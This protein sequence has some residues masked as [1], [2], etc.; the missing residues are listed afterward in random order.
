MDALGHRDHAAAEALVGGLHIGEERLEHEDA[1]RKVDQVRSV[2]MELSRHRRGRG[3]E[4]GVPAHDNYEVDTGQRC[5]IEVGTDERLGYKACRRWKSWR[6]I[7]AHQV[8]VDGFRNMDTAQR[9]AALACLLAEDAQGFGG[10]IAADIEEV[11]DSV[12]PQDLKDLLAVLGVGLVT[13]RTECWPRRGRDQL[14]LLRAFL[15][16]VDEVFGEDAGNAVTGAIDIFDFAEVTCCEH[17]AYQRVIDDSRRAATLSDQNFHVISLFSLGLLMNF[18]V[19]ETEGTKRTP[20]S[21]AKAKT[22]FGST[23]A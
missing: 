20:S 18:N 10:V 22:I 12:R 15:S 16:Q 9:I 8:I 23:S 6:V 2:I 11:I 5:V 21:N 13:R 1:L 7:I 14:E 19:F 17:E 4:S 3:Q